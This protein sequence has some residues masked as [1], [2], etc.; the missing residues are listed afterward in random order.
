MLISNRKTR[1]SFFLTDITNS[2]ISI[3]CQQLR[4]H[5]SSDLKLKMKC[6]TRA[7]IEDSKNIV[8][9]RL[10]KDQAEDTWKNVDDFNWLSK[11]TSSPNFSFQ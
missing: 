8:F 9:T 1:N 10:E 11:E 3:E 5:T 4:M 2:R 7:I 6:S